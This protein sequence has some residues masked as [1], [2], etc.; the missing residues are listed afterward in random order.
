MVDPHLGKVRFKALQIFLLAQKLQSLRAVA[1]AVNTSQP[2]VTQMLQELERTFGQTLLHRDRTGVKL[3]PA[4]ELLA[5]RA[6]VAMAEMST[7]AASLKDP[8][9]API[10]R[11]GTLPFLMFDLLPKTLQ[12]LNQAQQLT[13]RLR[14]HEA[15][16]GQ[17][18]ERLIQGDDDI[19]LTRLTASALD[20]QAFSAMRIH[21][22]AQDTLSLFVGQRHPL[23]SR[24]RKGES[25]EVA[26][27]A[28]CQWALPPESTETRQFINEMLVQRG[29]APVTALVDVSSLNGG[30]LMVSETH[31]VGAG[32]LSAIRRMT[33][34]LKL[35]PLTIKGLPPART[36]TV[37]IHHARQD[38][39]PEIG[40]FLEALTRTVKAAESA[41]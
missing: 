25:I 1:Q 5:A 7:A 2:A 16:V 15:T 9:P 22:L 28:D 19:V 3:T 30:M 20:G 37:A 33:G 29:L 40:R 11:V 6:R 13:L 39:N 8:V 24:A 35:A 10:L 32:P 41:V 38:I 34:M 26:K 12:A 27:L 21:H 36:Q 31:L 23:Y 18:R 4:G 14:L 17:L